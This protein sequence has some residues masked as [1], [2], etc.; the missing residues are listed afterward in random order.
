MRL[1]ALAP[2]LLILMAPLSSA[3]PPLVPGLTLTLSPEEME[4]R[5]STDPQ[6][7][8][9]DGTCTVDKIP[10]A[11]ATV[12]LTASCDLGWACAVSPSTLIFTNENPQ[13]FTLTVLVPGNVTNVTAAVRVDGRV[14]CTGLQN[15]ATVASTITV[16]GNLPVG[17]QLQNATDA[18]RTAT[19]GIGGDSEEASLWTNPLMLGGLSAVIFGSIVGGYLGLRRRKRA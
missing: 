17:A 10:L 9:F 18:N 13:S 8:H 14:M 15:T 19:W 12:D 2:S 16:T 7:P 6:N 4:L 5:A 1:A 3:Q 11:R